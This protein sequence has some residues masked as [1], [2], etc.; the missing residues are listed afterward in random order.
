MATVFNTV[1]KNTMLDSID[2]TFN[3]GTLEI[4]TGAPPG[5]GAVPSGTLLVS[6]TLPA[7]LWAAASGAVKA[8][9]AALATTAAVAAGTAGHFRIKA[10]GDTGAAVGTQHRIEG[11]ITLT[12]GGGDIELDNTS[13]T[14]GQNVTISTL[15]LT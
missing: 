14:V 2:A 15:N 9:N 11:T 5:P 1:T 10:T 13:I 4:R 8:L 6:I 7:D 12:A 3:G